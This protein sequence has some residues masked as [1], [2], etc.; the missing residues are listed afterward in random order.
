[1][2]P[3]G[4]EFIANHAHSQEPCSEGVFLVTALGLDPAGASLVQGLGGDGEA[5]LD[6]RLDFPGVGRA[7]EEPVFYRTFLEH[8]V[9]IQAVVPGIIIMIVSPAIAAIPDPFQ[10]LQ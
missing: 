7:V 10:L 8:A 4:G 6:I 1:M 5:K 9:E 3:G 2:E